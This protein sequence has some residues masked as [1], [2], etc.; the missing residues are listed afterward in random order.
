M[1]R[2]EHTDAPKAV[3][4]GA[5][6]CCRRGSVGDMCLGAP[7][8]QWRLC[9]HDRFHASYFGK[10]KRRHRA[11]IDREQVDATLVPTSEWDDH[12][13]STA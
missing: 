4:Q 6:Y 1:I 11:E 12:A 10:D 5:W 8:W 9:M 7:S 3:D 2:M 13:R